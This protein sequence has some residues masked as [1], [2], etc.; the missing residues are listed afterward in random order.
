MFS[1]SEAS[2]SKLIPLL[3]PHRKQLILG[4][5]CMV[6]YVACWPLLAKL[7]GELIPAIGDGN[8]FIVIKII[9]NAL[10]IFLLQKLCQF[11]QDI[12]LAKPA[13]YISQELRKKLFAKLQK[14]KLNSIEKFSTGDVTYRLTEDADRVGEVIYKTIQDTSPSLLQLIAVFGYMVFLDLQ[15]TIATL[16]LAP[17]IALLISVF[18]NKVMKA[19]EKSQKQVSD[20][21][22]LLSEAILGLPLVRAFAAEDWLQERFDLEVNY[23]R[24]ARYQTLKLLALQHPIVGFIEAFG[25]LTVL[26]IGAARIQS[27]GLDAQGF[28]SY[29]AALLMLIDPISHLTTNFNEF[30]QGQASLKRLMDLEKI[31]ME[32]KDITNPESIK[33]NNGEIVLQQI[34]FSYDTKN[35]ILK[36]INLKVDAGSVIALV[37]PSGAGKSTLFSLLLRFNSPEKGEILLDGQNIANLK[38]KELRT[39]IAIVPQSSSIFSGT[40]S[41]AIAFGRDISQERIIQ[42]AKL[43]NAHDFIMLMKNNYESKIEEGAK[44]LSGG[45][46][47]RIA[48]ARAILGNPSVLLLDEAT[49]ALDAK[50]EEAVKQGLQKAMHGRTVIIIAHRLATVQKA[51]HII[52][53][54]KG[55]IID[56]G[57]HQELI[58]R[59]G[60]YQ[61]FCDMQ[62]IKRTI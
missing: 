35:P 59:K 50:S 11:G 19:A 38:A 29:V 41:D 15:L 17:L 8:L 5:S 54:D 30:K 2:F 56:Q 26:A 33:K 12:L 42:A 58:D 49:S 28:S 60:K 20:L 40:I 21:A 34:Q 13:L 53:L 10:F 48:I 25:I 57:N 37:G 36:D 51:D 44:N 24:K 18:G 7:A 1:E 45:Q 14:S 61:D 23:H 3:K 46:L 43:S 55:T 6:T 9:I 16:L 39:K 22:G 62:I 27:G 31:P 52:V 4:T 32:R 47:Q